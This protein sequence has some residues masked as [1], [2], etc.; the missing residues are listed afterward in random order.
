MKTGSLPR[1]W[2]GWPSNP[3]TNPSPIGTTMRQ[4][5]FQRP[6]N[7]ATNT[8]PIWATTRQNGFQM[9]MGG[10]VIEPGYKYKPNT[11]HYDLGQNGFHGQSIPHARFNAG[12]IRGFCALASQILP[13]HEHNFL[14]NIRFRR[15]E[16]E[17]TIWYGQNFEVGIISTFSHYD[18]HLIVSQC[19][20]PFLILACFPLTLRYSFP[21]CLKDFIQKKCFERHFRIIQAAGNKKNFCNE[22]L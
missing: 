7:L 17:S 16:L 12:D 18:S 6:S 4:N 15:R 3:A 8:S 2:V 5:R 19:S 20:F 22:T 14:F 11:D 13:K 10:L 9:M 1:H 21:S